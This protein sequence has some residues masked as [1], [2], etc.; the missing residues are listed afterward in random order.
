[1]FQTANQLLIRGSTIHHI[2]QS[3][4]HTSAPGVFSLTGTGVSVW[5]A[6]DLSAEAALWRPGD[7]K[8]MMMMMIPWKSM[9]S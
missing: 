5:N 6:A 3:S 4:H 1:M 2:F 7:G 9:E 8:M